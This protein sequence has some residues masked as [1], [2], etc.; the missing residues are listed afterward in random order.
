MKRAICGM[1][2][3]AMLWAAQAALAA[4]IDLGDDFFNSEWNL[5]N[6]GLYFT[7]GEYFFVNGGD[8]RL[9]RLDDQL[10]LGKD[11]FGDRARGISRMSYMDD[12]RMLYFVADRLKG[13]KEGG[14][15]RVRFRDGVAE[16]EIEVL[17]KGV[18]SN[19]AINSEYIC[20]HVDGK[21]GIYRIDHDGGNRVK[22]SGHAIQSK[23]PAVRMHIDENGMLY[24]INE[25]DHF[26]WAVPVD[27]A[28]GGQAQMYIDRPMHYFTIVNYKRRNADAPEPVF[29]YVEY[30]PNTAGLDESHL[31]AVDSRGERVTELD[32]L[33][34]IQS[35][36]INTSKGVLYYIDSSCTPQVPRWVRLDGTQSGS[37]GVEGQ[38]DLKAFHASD[39]T[40]WAFNNRIGYIHI[41]GSW[42]VMAELGDTFTF[43]NPSTGRTDVYGGAGSDIWFVNT[44]TMENYRCRK[45]E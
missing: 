35:R 22:L 45:V 4:S 39:G 28:D 40:H 3:L 44:Q 41:I 16:G 2:L 1:L 24:Y 21:N 6:T 9:F 20:Y 7:D 37:V 10:Q 11:I 34:D 12:E 36:Y 38:G 33:R 14:L 31:A 42:M 17:V 25:K 30:A 26:L 5:N 18:V 19:Y 43:Y 13:K 15:C 27:A 29:I 23:N 8:G 32:F